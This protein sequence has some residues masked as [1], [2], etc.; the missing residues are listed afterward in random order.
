[1]TP[2]HELLSRIRWDPGFGR[3]KIVIGYYDRVAD[4]IIRV[5]LNQVSFEPG[6]RFSCLIADEEGFAHRVPLHRIREVSRNGR[7]IWQRPAGPGPQSR[8]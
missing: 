6:D 4:R 1:M 7:L 2:I 5:P 8:P 3:G